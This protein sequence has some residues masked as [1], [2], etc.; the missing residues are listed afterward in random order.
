MHGV[1]VGCLVLPEHLQEALSLFNA[2]LIIIGILTLIMTD[3]RAVHLELGPSLI[4]IVLS[5]IYFSWMKE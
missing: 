3:D 2:I 5:L 4:E 1:V